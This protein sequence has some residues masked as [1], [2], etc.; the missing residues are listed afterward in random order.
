MRRNLARSYEIERLDFT[1]REPGAAKLSPRANHYLSFFIAM[2]RLGYP[3][4]SIQIGHLTTI[5]FRL[6]GRYRSERTTYLALAELEAHGYIRR[7]KN[8]VG[9]DHFRTVILFNL[10]AFVYW[11]QIRRSNVVPYPT[12][13]HKVGLLQ[14][15]QEV[16]RRIT[17]VS[18]ITPKVTY[19]YQA[20]RARLKDNKSKKKEWRWLPVLYTLK[21]L[22]GGSPK[23]P[24]LLLA[25]A[26]CDGA[27]NVSGVDWDY[28]HRRWE[29]MTIPVREGLA[30]REIV[31][32]VLNALN[33]PNRKAVKSRSEAPATAAA[34]A[35]RTQSKKPIKS[36]TE[37][38]TMR[39]KPETGKD[40]ITNGAAIPAGISVDQV[41]AAI[42]Q[43]TQ[44]F[45]YDDNERGSPERSSPER[46]SPKVVLSDK[47]HAVL[48]SARSRVDRQKR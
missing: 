16:E 12:N 21:C 48:E 15:M 35:R 14:K 26:E 17:E 22:F 36:D 9:D 11:S 37:N 46:S 42:A 6:G 10:E 39:H 28:Y 31:P 43:L 30:S 20:Q 24:G 2:V 34:R 45:G 23:S 29:D 44:K 7:K 19:K 1:I 40:G 5:V 27:A 33:R 8:R 4:L 41:R 32:R 13:E 3:G 18:D 38:Q 47:E 25:K